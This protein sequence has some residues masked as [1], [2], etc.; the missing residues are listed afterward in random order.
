MSQ[1]KRELYKHNIYLQENDTRFYLEFSTP[2]GSTQHLRNH[3][4]KFN[5]H[6]VKSVGYKHLKGD[7]KAFGAQDIHRY[8]FEYLSKNEVT[9]ECWTENVVHRYSITMD[10]AGEKRLERQVSESTI[11][12]TIKDMES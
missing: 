2:V 4:F 11:Q 3:V 12:I 5:P 10:D 8:H 6:L 7:P 1:E 9:L